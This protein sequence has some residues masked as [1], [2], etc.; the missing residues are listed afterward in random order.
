MH[1]QT[2]VQVYRHICLDLQVNDLGVFGSHLL[3]FSDF[4]HF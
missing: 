1:V 2:K 3:N 4:S